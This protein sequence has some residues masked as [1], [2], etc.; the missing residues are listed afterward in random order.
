MQRLDYTQNWQNQLRPI[1]SYM[2]TILSTGQIFNATSGQRRR[3]F[4]LLLAPTSNQCPPYPQK[5]T[6]ELGREM[7][8]LCQKQTSHQI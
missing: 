6:S 8:A 5:Q 3:I 1:V 7:S 2:P 4:T